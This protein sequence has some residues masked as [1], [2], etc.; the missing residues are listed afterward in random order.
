[1]A[2]VSAKIRANGG[3]WPNNYDFSSVSFEFE[4]N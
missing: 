3:I 4:L 2:L 1:M